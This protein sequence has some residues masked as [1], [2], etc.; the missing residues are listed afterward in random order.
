M[1]MYTR[2]ISHALYLRLFTYLE[3]VVVVVF[4]FPFYFLLFVL[5]NLDFVTL[6]MPIEPILTDPCGWVSIVLGSHIVSVFIIN[7]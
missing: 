5:I 1:L 6:L 3:Q 4:S 2:N 7:K